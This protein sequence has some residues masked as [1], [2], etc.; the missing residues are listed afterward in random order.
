MERKLQ[1]L[2]HPAAQP[3]LRHELHQPQPTNDLRH[4][5]LSG[6]AVSPVREARDQ[7]LKHARIVKD[8]L[9]HL[10]CQQQQLL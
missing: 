1:T 9:R 6:R 5:V 8:N 10:C 7:V 2:P 3:R 4:A